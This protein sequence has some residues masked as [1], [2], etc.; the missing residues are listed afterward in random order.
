MLR[1]PSALAGVAGW[2]AVA[3]TPDRTAVPIPQA[4]AGCVSH[5]VCD[6]QG[7]VVSLQGFIQDVF[8]QRQI[9]YQFLQAAIL[10]FQFLQ[11]LGLVDL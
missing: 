6:A 1:P 10:F 9:C 8:I 5:I 2:I 11:P 4:A 7:L 3:P